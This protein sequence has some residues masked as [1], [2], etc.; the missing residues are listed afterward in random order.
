MESTIDRLPSKERLS[1][2]ELLKILAVV[3]IIVSHVVQTLSTW[4]GNVI[5]YS[6]YYINVRTP[7]SDP[8]RVILTLLRYAGSLGNYIFLCCSFWF[9]V[10]KNT[11]NTKKILRIVLDVFTISV[12]WLCGMLIGYGPDKLSSQDIIKS[13]LP[14]SHA[15]NWFITMYVIFVFISP[16]LNIIINHIDQKHHL[17]IAL[18]SFVCI[19]VVGYFHHFTIA[20]NFTGWITAYFV[21][22][23]FKR[24]GQKVCNSTLTNVLILSLTSISFIGFILIMNAYGLKNPDA[25]VDLLKWNKNYGMFD[26]LIAFS[27]LNLFNKMKFKN[28]F[29]NY[30]SSLSLL[31]YLIHENLLFRTYVRPYFWQLIYKTFGYTYILGWAAIY[32]VALFAAAVTVSIIYK[33]TLC[34]LVHLVSDLIY[35]GLSKVFNFKIKDQKTN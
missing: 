28:K 21:I 20:N 25:N 11:T 34:R 9:L 27:L 4:R 2:I 5:G 32:V 31:V 13:L 8:I 6:D 17:A 14:L 23:C 1:G 30:I 29:I 35:K 19:F 16:L 12:L 7:S 18:V 26:L 22:A 10:D 24:Y 3:L 33:E 15:N